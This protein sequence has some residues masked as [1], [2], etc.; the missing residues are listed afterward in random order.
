MRE[1][2]FEKFMKTNNIPTST[3]SSGV[4]TPSTVPASPMITSVPVPASRG[5]GDT[6]TKSINKTR[7]ELQKLMKMIAYSQQ[8][9]D[10]LLMDINDLRESTDLKKDFSFSPTKLEEEIA[11]LRLE[12]DKTKRNER[13]A[14]S[15]RDTL[16]EEM[17]FM[18]EELDILKS[19][20]EKGKQKL[21]ETVGDW[22][23]RYEE[24]KRLFETQR[25]NYE[26]EIA[27]LRDILEERDETIA[28]Q[29]EILEHHSGTKKDKRGTVAILQHQTSHNEM[30]DVV[31]HVEPPVPTDEETRVQEDRFLEVG[32]SPKKV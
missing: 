10:T 22:T 24:Q 29:N 32:K 16:K 4:S 20:I 1:E 11:V 28:Q 23:E 15:Q 19:L 25:R 8:L 30:K 3:T 17:K 2:Q 31:G 12:L 26:A 9:R 27:D 13:K 6:I 14:V 21:E 7:E 18:D 5:G